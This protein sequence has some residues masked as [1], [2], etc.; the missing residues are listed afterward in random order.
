MDGRLGLAAGAV[1]LLGGAMAFVGKKTLDMQAKLS[2]LQADI[3][4]STGMSAEEVKNL[5]SNLQKLDTRTSMEGLLD[6]AKVGGQLGVAKGEIEGFTNAVDKAVVALGDEFGGG[7]EE[8]AREIGGIQ[9]LFKE[10]KDLAAGDAIMSIGNAINALGAAGTATGPVVADFTQRLGALGSLGPKLGDTLGLGAM[11]QEL[12]LTAEQAAGGVTNILL[13][14]GQESENF[15]KKLSM[16]KEQ[17]KELLNNDPNQV[18]VKLAESLKGASN[19][20]IVATLQ[21]LKIGTQESIKVVSLLSSATDTLAQ[22]QKFA[23]DQLKSTDSIMSEFN[24]KNETL[25]ANLEKLGKSYDSI[26]ANLGNE[27]E[28]FLNNSIKLLDTFIG[29]VAEAMKSEKTLRGE[30]LSEQ[31]KNTA[32]NLI[33]GVDTRATLLATRDPRV[34]K[35]SKQLDAVKAEMKAKII[36]SE[37]KTHSDFLNQSKAGLKDESKASDKRKGGF[38]KWMYGNADLYSVQDNNRKKTESMTA[39]QAMIDALKAE[40]DK[41][42]AVD[43]TKSN[44]PSFE[45]L[46]EDSKVDK[47]AHNAAKNITININ[48]LQ[49]I[50]NVYLNDKREMLGAMERQVEDVLLNVVNN[51]NQS[52]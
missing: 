3:R 46:K 47:T 22:K 40:Q 51:V 48:T 45:K 8:V 39:S 43:T 2:D 12:G 50:E 21:K 10:T 24:V 34:M 38:S 31:N 16:T 11:L 41:L 33:D 15:A 14:A 37:L 19:T 28:G 42:K 30:R 4:K 7:A 27:T 32:K 6:I 25:A 52:Y 49:G 35:D 23:N 36:Q 26:F 5:Q 29:K 44:A 18:L 20:E 9:K 17:F 1:G 13:K